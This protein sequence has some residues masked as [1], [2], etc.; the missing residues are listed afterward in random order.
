M[1]RKPPRAQDLA[2]VTGRGQPHGAQVW[3]VEAAANATSEEQK[4]R[5]DE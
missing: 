1:L 2:A 5:E 4:R 3:W